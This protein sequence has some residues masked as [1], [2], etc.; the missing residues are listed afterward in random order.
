LLIDP[1]IGNDGSISKKPSSAVGDPGEV[2]QQVLKK[3]AI[4][5]KK[6]LGKE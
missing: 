1:T 5:L 3:E 6:F 2:A 4:P